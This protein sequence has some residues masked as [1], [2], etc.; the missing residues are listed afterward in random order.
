M[1]DDRTTGTGAGEVTDGASGTVLDDGNDGES[2]G[3]APLGAPDG[4]LDAVSEVETI[5]DVVDPAAFSRRLP[6]GWSVG[7]EV[8]PF[9]DEPLVEALLVE[10]NLDDPRL[11]LKPVE[12]LDPR[13]QIECYERRRLAGGREQITSTDSLAEAV[14]VATN[15]V[16]QQRSDDHS[17]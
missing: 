15:W 3:D 1:G 4:G 6:D 8:I 12:M 16:H 14:R 7:I 9:D 5:G 17:V 11:L 10:R 13:G 2:G